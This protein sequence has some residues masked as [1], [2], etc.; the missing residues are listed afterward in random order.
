MLNTPGSKFLKDSISSIFGSKFLNSL[1]E[2]NFSFR[3]KL[4]NEL[5]HCGLVEPSQDVVEG[6]IDHS[7]M[8]IRSTNKYKP[9]L[10]FSDTNNDNMEGCEGYQCSISGYISRYIPDNASNGSK[11]D[12]DKQYLFCNGRPVD[13]PKITKT[14]YEV[15]FVNHH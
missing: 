7:V 6:E 2:I 8:N 1:Q 14:I 13:M 3:V 15:K 5:D 4:N 9:V 12:Q 11:G 10:I